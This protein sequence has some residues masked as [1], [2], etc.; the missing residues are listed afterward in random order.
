VWR[1]IRELVDD[2]QET[3]GVC[4]TIP[5]EI[6]DVLNSE[7]CSG[8][9]YIVEMIYVL[10]L[11]S[12]GYVYIAIYNFSSEGAVKFNMALSKSACTDLLQQLSKCKLP[13]QCAH[14]RNSTFTAL[15]LDKI[16]SKEVNIDLSLL[17][18]DNI[19]FF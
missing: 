15:D 18:F 1:L 11:L 17:K 4:L 3:R 6:R 8:E 16:K 12:R 5:K 14:G 7:A 19:P 13:F 9:N 2:L 10:L